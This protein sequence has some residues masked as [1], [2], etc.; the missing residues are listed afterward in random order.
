MFGLKNSR[1][2][3]NMD[4]NLSSASDLASS[5]PK[6]KHV[7]SGDIDSSLLAN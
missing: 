6:M 3:R 1:L 7:L 5:Y 4:S 2:F